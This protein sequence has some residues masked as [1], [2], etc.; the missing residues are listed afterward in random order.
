MSKLIFS[1]PESNM[2]RTVLN[3]GFNQWRYGVGRISCWAG[4]DWEFTYQTPEFTVI[5]SA[6]QL[7]EIADK[8]DEMKRSAQ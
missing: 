2:V 7:R 1:E 6:E 5:L 4:R 8:M 3:V